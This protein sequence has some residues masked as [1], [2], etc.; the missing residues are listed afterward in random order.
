MG[1]DC[2]GEERE[3]SGWMDFEVGGRAEAALLSLLERL[4][5]AERCES[6]GY[7]VYERMPHNKHVVRKYG[8]VKTTA[9]KISEPT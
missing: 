9:R 8:A 1:V 3:G 7:R 5:K 4:L 2:G 6:D